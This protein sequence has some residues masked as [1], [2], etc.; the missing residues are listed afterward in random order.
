MSNFNDENVIDFAE[1]VAAG[2]IQ[3]ATPPEEF[4]G[5]ILKDE[6]VFTNDKADMMI[7]QMFHMFYQMVYDNKIGLM[8]AK[9]TETGAIETLIV[10]TQRTEDGF[11]C[12][13]IAKVLP[14][15][16]QGKYQSPDGA[17]NYV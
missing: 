13:P 16:E 14:D 7:R 5:E 17:G 11:A 9:N 10:G 1:R 8:H 2:K 15:T 6:L 4:E 12:F 3:Q